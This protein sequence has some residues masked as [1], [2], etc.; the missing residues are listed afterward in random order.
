MDV[1]K[2]LGSIFVIMV[3]FAVLTMVFKKPA[4]AGAVLAVPVTGINGL[5]NALEGRPV[6]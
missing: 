2:V 1:T 5:T 6:P 3:T 4:A